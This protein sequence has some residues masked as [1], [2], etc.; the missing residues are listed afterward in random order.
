MFN[1]QTADALKIHKDQCLYTPTMTEFN[2]VYSTVVSLLHIFDSKM[3]ADQDSI[4]KYY[5]PPTVCD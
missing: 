4:L 1:G 5:L 2:A 3:F